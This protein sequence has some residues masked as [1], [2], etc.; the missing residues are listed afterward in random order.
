MIFDII[1]EGCAGVT[2]KNPR[3]LATFFSYSLRERVTIAIIVAVSSRGS[4]GNER[5]SRGPFCDR[6]VLACSGFCSEDDCALNTF[7]IPFY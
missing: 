2:Q 7:N 5:N 6:V 3:G 1:N 4:S